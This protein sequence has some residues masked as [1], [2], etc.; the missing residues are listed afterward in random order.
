MVSKHVYL[1]FPLTGRK[2]FPEMANATLSAGGVRIAV[3]GASI[4][5]IVE[6]YRE[7]VP[8]GTTAF[9]NGE[10]ADNDTALSDGDEVTFSKPAGAKG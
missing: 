5:E 10:P 7:V 8:E 3:E 9:V 1:V 2:E 4:A 6:L